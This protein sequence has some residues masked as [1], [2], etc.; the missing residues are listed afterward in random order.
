MLFSVAIYF[1]LWKPELYFKSSQFINYW[2]NQRF[3]KIDWIHQ[4]PWDMISFKLRR[5][6]FLFFHFRYFWKRNVCYES[7]RETAFLFLIEFLERKIT[8]LYIWWR[9]HDL[10]D[11]SICYHLMQLD[12]WLIIKQS[13]LFSLS[14]ISVSI[15]NPSNKKCVYPMVIF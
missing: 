7:D 1:P 14:H 15:F 3:I 2:P 4:L 8:K 5:F 9:R 6:I 10:C 12:I 11:L 13:L